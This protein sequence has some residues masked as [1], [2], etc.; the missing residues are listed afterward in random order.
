MAGREVTGH[1]VQGPVEYL[2]RLF[3]VGCAQL[4]SDL[5]SPRALRVLDCPEGGQAGW[6]DHQ[7]VGPAMPEV[8][9][10][11][12]VALV[13]EQVGE[14]LDALA[15]LTHLPGDVGDGGR[16]ILDRFE[17]EPAGERLTA[18]LGE[19]L[20]GDAEPVVEREHLHQEVSERPPSRRP[21][22]FHIDNI[23]SIRYHIVIIPVQGGRVMTYLVTGATGPI[24][25]SLVAQLLAAG[26]TVRVTT[27]EPEQAAFGA[28]V[29]VVGGNF[30][31]GDLPAGA[32]AGVTK[33]FV[34][35]AD[36][37][38][39]GFLARAVEAGVGHLVVLSSLAAAELHARDRGSVSN[40]HHRAIEQAVAASG[41]PA[42]ILRPGDMATNLL[43]WAWS[44]K[45]S[46]A[47]Y[48]PYPT[49]AQAPIHE[50]DI[51]AVAARA[52][53]DNAHVGKT[54]PLTGPEAITRAE[55][56]AT[57]G[58]AIG[59]ELSYV[60]ITAEAFA[61]Q[62][63]QYMPAPVIKMLLDYWSDTVSAPDV[64]L[65]TVEEVTG[66]PART[67][68]TWAADHRADFV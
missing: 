10:V 24:G 1:E 55:M 43:F 68:A 28:P 35:P 6:G 67:L 18:G 22:G 7:Q 59:R 42:T 20:T 53:L 50:A 61:R 41:I 60:E 62:M 65:R 5:V 29:E 15:R 30:A 3:E 9:L 36:G 51:A 34:F 45:T 2:L 12:G 39:D 19:H 21:C 38:I 27:R 40:R 4:C 58:A 14:A 37:G 66:R 26:A 25:R 11:R 49:S 54:Y 57:I 32:L 46:G 13:D 23:L 56:L 64:P 31:T 17:H 16:V 44:I 48:G 8:R 33:A 47:V 52:L 63:A